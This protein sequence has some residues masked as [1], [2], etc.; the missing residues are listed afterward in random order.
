MCNLKKTSASIHR[1]QRRFTSAAAFTLVELLVVIGIIALLISILLPALGRARQSANQVKCAA[2]LRTIGQAIAMYAGD[3]KGS[4]PFGFVAGHDTNVGPLPLHP[5]DPSTDPNQW[6]LGCDWS[7]LLMHQ[8]NSK[9]GS[10]YREALAIAQKE[11]F[12]GGWA[13]SRS[14]FLCPEVNGNLLPTT[15][16]LILH[17]S[18][19]P[20]L[21]PDLAGTDWWTTLQ[22]GKTTP[23]KGYR[24]SH[25]KR[26]AE[27][28]IVFDGTL[29]SRGGNWTTSADAYALD[30]DKVQFFFTQ[31]TTFL[32]DD[33]ANKKNTGGALTA[34]SSVDM[35]PRGLVNP[36][37]VDS[38]F[39]ADNDKNWGNIRFRHIGDTVANALMLDG[40]VQSFHY[41]K[42][43]HTTDLLRSN[44][45]VTP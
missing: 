10:D 38:D 42:L 44:I 37:G 34:A 20:R 22:T 41:N 13:G 5:Y 28:V 8:T 9:Y 29:T 19:N 40:H 7:T 15:P 14:Y 30:N 17:Y 1:P 33:Y 6:S 36:P 3:N 21:M 18:T 23:L 35:T 26:A 12:G 25:V 11:G 24:I 31:P 27:I 39:N 43:Q 45:N 4:L 16:S 32:T 2:N